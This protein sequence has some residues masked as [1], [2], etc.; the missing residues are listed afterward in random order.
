MLRKS[1]FKLGFVSSII[2]YLCSSIVCLAAPAITSISPSSG[3]SNG[4]TEVTVHGS[5]FAG[6]SGGYVR[7]GLK[8]VSYYNISYASDGSWLRFNTPAQQAGAANITVY[9]PDGQSATLDNGYTYV[10]DVIYV[11]QNDSTCGGK[12]P[13]YTSISEAIGTAATG[14]TIFIGAGSYTEDILLT[15]PKEVRLRGGWN[16]DFSA[17]TGITTLSRAPKAP[18]GSLILQDLTIRPN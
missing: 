7:I 6:G 9:N 13:C 15:D 11:A 8:T 10:A 17:Q 14:S 2:T 4:G 1:I 12:E 18:Q 5:G 16:S 3:P